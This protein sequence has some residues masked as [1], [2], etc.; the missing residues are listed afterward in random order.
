MNQNDMKEYAIPRDEEKRILSALEKRDD[1]DA[2]RIERY[3]AMPDLSRTEGSPIKELVDKI[4]SVPDYKDFDRIDS[5]E[6]V[7]TEIAF[8]LFDFAPNHPARSKSDTY[9]ADDL[10]ILRPHTTVM[11]YYY[12]TLDEIKK[13]LANREEIG[14]FSFGKVYRKDEIDK[15]HMN[16]F[17]QIDALYLAPKAKKPLGL[18]DLQ[19]VETKIVKSVFGQD[20]E[21]RFHDE[22][23]PYTHPSTEIE[24]KKGNDWVE[25]LGSGVV[26]GSVLEKLGVDSSVYNGWAF[27]FGLERWAIM[28]MQL[29][30]IRLL[31]SQDPRVQKQLRLGH[32]YEEV[33]KY[34]PVVRDISFIVSSE[35]V[36]NNYFDLI[37]ETVGDDMVEEVK[38]SDKYE[39]VKKF[40]TGKVSYTYRIV[41]RSQERTLT[42]AEVDSLHK[43]LEQAT[44]K[45][46]GAQIR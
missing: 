35:F 17:H 23:F 42:N 36:P 14:V 1:A 46:Y 30:D 32:L 44:T 7:P 27:G 26:K 43:A 3:L 5:P 6:I 39:D 4:T 28:S 29:P 40:G 34:P 16:V 8:D 2:M 20:I 25:I 45:L 24:M 10:H 33:S 11:W 31:W 9:F 21:Y 12:L 13:R 41:Y 22:T 19:D 15:T 18:Q 38:L 37:R